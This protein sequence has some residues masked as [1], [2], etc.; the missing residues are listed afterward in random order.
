[1]AAAAG[2]PLGVKITLLM[3]RNVLLIISTELLQLLAEARRHREA[4]RKALT[5]HFL[6]SSLPTVWGVVAFG[7]T[8]AVRCGLKSG[9]QRG[10]NPSLGL[11]LPPPL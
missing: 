9:R 10:N 4:C 2:S 1:M 6:Q 11:R 3:A 7:T 5:A 8:R